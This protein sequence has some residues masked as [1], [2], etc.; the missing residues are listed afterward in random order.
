M[1]KAKLEN[2]NIKPIDETWERFAGSDNRVIYPSDYMY[3][4]NVSTACVLTNTDEGYGYIANITLKAEPIKNLNLMA[5]YTLTESKEISGMPGSDAKSA[6]SSLYTVD[7][8]NYATVQRS[9]YVTPHRFI[10]S[11]GY[12]L[13]WNK[14]L[15]THINLF[16]SCYSPSGYSYFYTNDM[17]GDG[18][19]ADLI[20]IPK[21]EN[22]IIW[23]GSEE[24]KAKDAADFWAFVEQDSYLKNHKGEYAEAYSAYAPMVH[25]FDLRLTQD[26]KFKIG[27]TNHKIELSLDFMNIGN[28]LKSSWGVIKNMSACNNGAILKYAGQVA[29]GEDMGKPMFSLY[30][31]KAGNA[32]TKTWEY[33]RA[34]DQ[35]WQLQLGARYTF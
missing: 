19:P 15:A 3:N 2:Y 25:R 24:Q 27:K 11:A 7:G 16:Y 32:P 31:D 30:R 9:R 28:M 34:T 29:E 21:D 18:N 35:C 6:W 12:G 20:Y 10:A 14:S 4:K 22:D 23:A 17:N 5:A 1:G 33:N 13:D 26:F 8:S